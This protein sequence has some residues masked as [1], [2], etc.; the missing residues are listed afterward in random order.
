MIIS[1][2]HILNIA[3]RKT[4]CDSPVGADSHGPKS[5]QVTLQRMQAE[6]RQVHIL[7]SNGH[8]QTG[9]DIP[10]LVCMFSYNTARIILFVQPLQPFMAYRA[11]HKSQRNALRYRCQSEQA[12]RGKRIRIGS[13]DCWT[14]KLGYAAIAA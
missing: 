4:K 8:I 5:Y 7:G 2:I 11:D 12:R 1:V 9:Q 6:S 13:L 14:T 10:Q 3:V